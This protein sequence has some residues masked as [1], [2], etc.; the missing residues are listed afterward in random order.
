MSPKSPKDLAASLQRFGLER[1][2]MRAAL[3]RHAGI[4][5]TDLDA[6]EHLEADGPLTQRDL[7]ERLSI[8]SGAVTML[9]DRLEAACW[10]VRRPHPDD[11]RYTLIELSAQAAAQGPAGLATYHASIQALV[12]G[13]PSD[14]RRAIAAFLQAAAEAASKAAQDLHRGPA[15]R[16]GP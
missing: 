2:R 15:G 4:S 6:L 7:G 10:V 12:T 11:R 14:K 8:T 5:A 1:D 9:V 13:V 3:A 16:G